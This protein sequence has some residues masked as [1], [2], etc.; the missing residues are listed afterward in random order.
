MEFSF[1]PSP[2]A[3]L[4]VSRYD[5]AA[6]PKF[7]AIF[8]AGASESPL[9]NWSQPPE[10]AEMAVVMANR[11]RKDI[12]ALRCRWLGTSKDGRTDV[13]RVSSDSY[14]V[15]V[16]HAV[17]SA[18]DRKLI[19]P[20]MMLD[21][22]LL[23]HVERGGGAIGG[24]ISG[25][26]HEPAASLRLEFDL[27][28]FADGEIAGPDPDRYAGELQCRKPAAEFVAKQI[29]KAEAK[30][31]DVTPVLTALAEVPHLGDDFLANWVQHYARDFLRSMND[32]R[33]RTAKLRH[34][35]NRPALPKFYRR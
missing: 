21:E 31:Q 30:G 23:D 20:A 11:T 24:V 9:R 4:V 28:V 17:L 10:Q 18:G 6:F 29:R 7:S 1:S 26:Q 32:E 25:G 16:Y 5:P 12:T 33:M 13:R 34:L 14:M 2:I 19:C 8:T 22:S 15:D 27:V 35:E 3:E